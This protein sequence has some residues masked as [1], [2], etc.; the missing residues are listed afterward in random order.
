[1]ERLRLSY[2]RQDS[3]LVTGSHFAAANHNGHYAGQPEKSPVIGPV[4]AG[5]HEPGFEVVELE[6]RVTQAGDLDHSIRTEVEAGAGGKTEE[7]NATGR[8][9][10]THVTG[11]DVKAACSKGV[12]QLSVDEM[13]LPQ[14]GLGRVLLHPRTVLDGG[15][16]VGVALN[17]DAFDKAYA[18]LCGFAEGMA[19]AAVDR[20]DAGVHRKSKLPN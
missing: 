6:A 20:D 1:L 7:A 12:V 19:A 17:A 14:V 11:L 8:D 4:E 10:L 2:W 5:L 9:A 13:Y 3:D 16:G 15:T 18:F